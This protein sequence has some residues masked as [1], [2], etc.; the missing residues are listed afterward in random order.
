MKLAVTVKP[1]SGKDTVEKLADGSFKVCVRKAPE[2]GKANESV[3]EIL[4]EHFQVP[5]SRV[6]ILRGETSRK[7]IISISL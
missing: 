2:K 4:A 6:A 7:K 3:R 1:L 5:K